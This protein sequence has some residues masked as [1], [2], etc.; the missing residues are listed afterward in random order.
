VVDSLILLPLVL[1]PTVTGFFLIT[2]L[3]REGF[4][5][6]WLADAFGL[7]IV[8][9]PIA[10]IVASSIVALPI[11]VKTAQ[12]A[13]ESVPGELEEVGLTLRLSPLWVFFR[14]TLPA[15]WQGITAALVLGFT[16]AIGEFGA[17]LMF[18]GNI[19]GRTNTMPLEIFAAFQAGNQSRAEYYVIALSIFSVLVVLVASSLAP[20]KRDT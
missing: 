8:F 1:P 15:A 17:T 6:E 9:S 16:R 4:I 2:L 18:A 14:I 7:Q 13:L 12:P 19:P 10:A 3:G 20:R 11:V 5:G